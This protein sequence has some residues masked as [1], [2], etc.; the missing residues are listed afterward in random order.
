VKEWI[1]QHIVS[2]FAHYTDV[3]DTLA[4]IIVQK[5]LGDSS[6]IENS[7][8]CINLRKITSFFT[9]M[10]FRIKKDDNE[11]EFGRDT[12]YV[13]C[14]DNPLTRLSSMLKEF[15]ISIGEFIAK[16]N[17]IRD[18]L[19]GET[20]IKE[21]AEFIG[22]CWLVLPHIKE[23][24]EDKIYFDNYNHY[25]QAIPTNINSMGMGVN[26]V[27]EQLP[28]TK[29]NF[30]PKYLILSFKNLPT[31]YDS[32]KNI[33]YNQHHIELIMKFFYNEYLY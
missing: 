3:R 32:F 24:S 23:D 27:A 22:P 6:N 4:E 33:F 29:A 19:I 16:Y 28:Q 20:L 15:N 2:E 8:K 31:S 21:L 5:Y 13:I 10:H 30:F 11:I 12:N 14:C 17:T 18:S 25:N 7:T 1:T 9:N 26:C